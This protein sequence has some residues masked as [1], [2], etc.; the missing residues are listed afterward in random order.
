MFANKI[1][2]DEKLKQTPV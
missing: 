2:E 1:L